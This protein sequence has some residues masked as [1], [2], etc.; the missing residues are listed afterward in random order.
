L[1]VHAVALS[2]ADDDGHTPQLVATAGAGHERGADVGLLLWCQRPAAA[3]AITAAVWPPPPPALPPLAG[4]ADSVFG[5]AWLSGRALLSASR[6]GTVKAWRLPDDVFQQEDPGQQQQQPCAA[7]SDAHGGGGGGGGSGGGT[8]SA[9]S[10]APM[11][12]VRDVRATG[13]P[14]RAVSV[15]SDGG[16]ATWDAGAGAGGLRLAAPV[17]RVPLLASA[18]AAAS[19]AAAAAASNGPL[20]SPPPPPPPEI[21]N[22]AARGSLAA[23][24]SRLGVTL[25]D[26]RVAGGGGSAAAAHLTPP[27]PATA[28]AVSPSPLFRAAPDPCWARS[29]CLRS[30]RSHHPAALPDT[31]SVGTVDGRLLLYDLRMASSSSS[32]GHALLPEAVGAAAGGNARLLAAHALSDGHLNRDHPNYRER[33]APLLFPTS[34]HAHAWE[35]ERWEAGRGG[36]GGVAAGAAIAP[37]TAARRVFVGGGPLPSGVRGCYMGVWM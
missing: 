7:T 26:L 15:A 2:P 11:P 8:A 9:S 20:Q 31:L 36:G 32:D 17:L 10:T 1:G 28:A 25:V 30:S 29:V 33:F 37:T 13:E 22:L 34:A 21:S 4:H 6:D 19:S 24:A 18:A 12:R 23:V 14:G 16:L 5:V 35:P 27:P 3:V